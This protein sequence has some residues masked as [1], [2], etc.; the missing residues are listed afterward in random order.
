NWNRRQVYEVYR[1]TG[2]PWVPLGKGLKC[3]PVNIGPRSTPNYDA[4]AREAVHSLGNGVK[5]FAGQRREGFYVDLGSIF[6]LGDLRPFQNLHLI[7]TAAT[8][9]VDTLKNSNVH[10]MAIQVPKSQLTADG[11]NP[12]DVM[13]AKSVIGVYARASRRKARIQNA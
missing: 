3:P 5:V 7:P 4:L 2:G 6:D 13:A 8:D 9:G 10:T 1:W 12:T 11:S